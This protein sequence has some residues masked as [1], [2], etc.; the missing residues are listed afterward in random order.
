MP[1][2]HAPAP[3]QYGHLAF[4]DQPKTLPAGPVAIR[5]NFDPGVAGGH[6]I[7]GS[8]VAFDGTGEQTIARD[9]TLNNVTVSS[10]VTLTTAAR[11]TVTGVLSNLG[12]TKELRAVSSPGVLLL[13]LANIALDVTT[14][15]G[16]SSEEVVRRDESHPNAAEPIKTGKWWDR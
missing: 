7:A 16:L 15:G 8:A 11:I 10:S 13:G 4:N 3:G 12:W 6:T 14:P 9:V 5:G 1:S 2:R